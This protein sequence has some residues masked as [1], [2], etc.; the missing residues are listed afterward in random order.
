[1]HTI[2]QALGSPQYST[3]WSCRSQRELIGNGWLHRRI[4]CSMCTRLWNTCDRLDG[5]CL[6]R[7][8][9]LW[10]RVVIRSKC[11]SRVPLRWSKRKPV[12]VCRSVTVSMIKS[13]VS[14]ILNHPRALVRCTCCSLWG[15]HAL[16]SLHRVVKDHVQALRLLMLQ[17]HWCQS[18]RLDL[19]LWM[20]LLLTTSH[21]LMMLVI[22]LCLL[23]IG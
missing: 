5:I 4:Q 2:R 23:Q 20:V 19:K 11:V 18:M 6:P 16:F 9:L 21:Y 12:E 17:A 15:S 1:M 10:H 22:V 7:P 3:S 13:L 8:R 14:C